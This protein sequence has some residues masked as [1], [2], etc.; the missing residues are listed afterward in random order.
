[1]ATLTAPVTSP[2]P[3]LFPLRYYR[4]TCDLMLQAVDPEVALENAGEA[5]KFYDLRTREILCDGIGDPE[6]TVTVREV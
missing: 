6:G 4:V 5:L 2:P 3:V 1:M